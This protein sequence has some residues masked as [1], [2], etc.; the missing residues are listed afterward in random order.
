MRAPTPGLAVGITQRTAPLMRLAPKPFFAIVPA[1]LTI[2]AL[3]LH[4]VSA[5]SGSGVKVGTLAQLE[6]LLGKPESARIPAVRALA[7]DRSAEVTTAL[8]EE[9]NRAESAPYR[10]ALLDAVGGVARDGVTEI[11]ALLAEHPN[12][13]ALERM[14][15]ARGLAKQ[16]PEAVRQ[17]GALARSNSIPAARTY[18]MMALSQA[19]TD[20]SWRLLAEAVRD[21]DTTTRSQGIRYLQRAPA[22]DVVTEARLAAAGDT[23]PTTASTAVRQLAEQ[24]HE[25]A[26]ELV[27]QVCERP[28]PPRGSAAVDLFHAV[29][30]VFE[31]S[32]HAYAL[33][34]A[35]DVRAAGA[36]GNRAL[37]EL[38]PKLIADQA[39]LDHVRTQL[40]QVDDPTQVRIGL[41]ILA[42]VP[43]G[44]V[45]AEI[46]ELTRSRDAGIVSTALQVLSDR[47]DKSVLPDLD[48][49]LRS[50]NPGL[51][52]ETL[53][54]IHALRE[55][56]DSWN[57]EL[58]ER[59]RKTS[60]SKRD[61]A[62]YGLMLSLLGELGSEEA[63][64]SAW[65]ALE[66]K[67]WTV[68]AAAID[69]CGQVRSVASVPEL[70]DRL[71]EENGRLREDL[72]DTLR[73]LTAM[74][75]NSQARWRRWWKETEAGF[76]LIPA[77]AFA[78]EKEAK[79]KPRAA[80]T[81]SYYG[82]PMVSDRVVFVV[83]VSGSMTAK[84]GTGGN[85]S[86]LDE[87]KRQLK[88]VIESRPKEF[89][90]NVVSFHSTVDTIFDRMTRMAGRSRAE[91]I[92]R[93]DAL[94]PI[95]ATNV[96]DALKRAF[97]ETDLDTIYLLSDG[98]PSAGPI[99]DPDQLADTV[100][101]WNRTR[102]LR[103]HCISIGAESKMLRRIA[104]ESG[105]DYAT[106]R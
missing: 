18:A 33:Q 3:T 102:R 73:S 24:K 56:D 98:A 31:P 79:S 57:D 16:G 12:T 80:T 103:I 87:A 37:E 49:L 78:K 62:E 100:K 47:G 42:E 77:D 97:E 2:L 60:R 35:G 95:G 61:F 43:G 67:N 21:G 46:A 70:I 11:L 51:R 104:E 93:V 74:R 63:L 82:I 90:F 96:H 40:K 68:R 7:R 17:L 38:L 91:A 54:C 15:A 58:L 52:L 72:L 45:S 92:K 64:E 53:L 106:S 89:V 10:L 1:L 101:Q 25:R 65:K 50:K 105:G 55:A 94:E 85:R 66:H 32:L 83:D 13:P 86:R 28:T 69:F 36:N 4:T 9:L 26:L 6:A 22:M 5:Q 44:E 23:S 84:I 76:E 30:A 75:F 20:E 88:R 41:Q 34:L 99:T 19:A 48:K 27:R 8:L 71:D 14:R 39:F 81:T 59:L 29:C